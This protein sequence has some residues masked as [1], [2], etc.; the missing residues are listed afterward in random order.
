MAY[1]ENLNLALPVDKS[2]VWGDDV[3]NNFTKIDTSIGNLLDDTTLE[4]GEVMLKNTMEYP[5]SNGEKT[6][7]LK[8][9]RKNINYTVQ[10]EVV[11]ADGIVELS[12]IYGKQLNGF[13]IS[14]VGNAKNVNVR[15]FV[16][17]GMN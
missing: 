11:S 4:V 16:R 9:V 10:A 17:G 12:N 8:K 1:T 15:Y 2:P 14:C 7:A 5:F 6:I 13:K 3:R